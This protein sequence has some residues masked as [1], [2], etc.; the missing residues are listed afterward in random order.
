MEWTPISYICSPR[1]N[2]RSNKKNESELVATLK[3]LT[4]LDTIKWTEC[5]N[6]SINPIYD[7][8][9]LFEL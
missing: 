4:T 6:Q 8:L 3:N 7:N 1:Y 9:T 5:T 2:M